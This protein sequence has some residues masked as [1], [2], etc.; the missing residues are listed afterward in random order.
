[1]KGIIFDMDGVLVDSMPTHVRSWKSAFAEIA[2][3]TVTERDLYLLEGMRGTELISKIFEQEGVTD[4]SLADTV[5]ER[6]N[7]IF[8]SIRSSKPFEGVPEMID[9]LAC[10]K[11]VVSGS[12]RSDV[13]TIVDQDFGREKF[14]AIVSADDIKSGKPDPSAFLEALNRMGIRP[15]DAVVVENAPL[16]PMTWF[17]V[18]G[19]AEVLFRPADRD[20]LAAFLAAKPADAP[21]T[22]IGVGSNLLV[23]DGGVP[24]VVIRLGRGFA[25]ISVV[26]GAPP[27]LI[28]HR[29][30]QIDAP[31]QT[32]CSGVGRSARGLAAAAADVEDALTRL[33]GGGLRQPALISGDRGV[34]ALLMGHPVFALDAV[35]RRRLLLV[36]HRCHD[37]PRI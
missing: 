32:G 34:V 22:V 24:G 16:G 35:P 15:S 2:G 13:E 21:V 11:A 7:R 3:I 6:K 37:S 19:P 36:C 33:H 29:G 8:K 9:A 30:R 28:Q 14:S 10:T 5:H 31:H 25:D 27:R 26:A 1:M 12:T 17:R 20:D 18:G 4:G 23:R